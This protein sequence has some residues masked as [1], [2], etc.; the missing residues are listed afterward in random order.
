M[1]SLSKKKVFVLQDIS[2]TIS[3][4]ISKYV[5]ALLLLVIVGSAFAQAGR[6][7]RANHDYSHLSYKSAARKYER[8]IGRRSDGVPVQR[9]LANCYY[10]MSD[11][12]NAEKYF[13]MMI[14]SPEATPDD[15]FRY[16][17]ALK[18]NGKLDASDTYMNKLYKKSMA[19]TRAQELIRDANYM[20]KLENQQPSFELKTLSVNTE[21]S[22]F[23]GYPNPK[24]KEEVY[25]ISSRNNSLAVKN[26][27][28]WDGT[29]FLDV[30][31]G[32]VAADGAISNPKSVRGDVNTKYH[33]GPLTFTPNADYVYFTRNN[34]MGGKAKYDDNRIQN[35]HLYK[36][37]VDAKGN[38]DDEVLLPF[39]DRLYSVGH[40][41][42]SPD[43]SILYFASDMPGGFGGVDLYKVAINADGTYGKPENLGR[44]INSEGNEMFPWVSENGNFF[45]SSNGHLGYGGLDVFV[46]V[47]G[48]S[49]ADNGIMNLGK[50]INS[51]RDD[52]AF[53]LNPDCKTGYVSSNREGGL[54]DDDIYSVKMIKN[55]IHP[56]NVNGKITDSTSKNVLAFTT[57]Y[58]KDGNGAIIDST[59]TDENGNYT[60]SV[61]SESNFVISA[62][63]Q[64]YSCAERKITTEGLPQ[65]QKEVVANAALE[66]NFD[67]NLYCLV[68]NSKTSKPVHNA[69]ISVVD[70]VTGEVLM[71]G[72]TDLTGDLKTAVKNRMLGETL[73][74]IVEVEAD[75]FFPK[76]ENISVTIE[77]PGTINL[78][79]IMNFNMDQIEVGV[80]LAD[81]INLKPIYFDL[82]KWNIRRDAAK[83]LDKIVALMNKYPN[84]V[85]EL[86]SHTDCRSSMQFNQDLSDKRAKASAEY[87]KAKISDPDRIYGKGYGE[88]RL[89]VNCPCEGEVKSDC[90]ESEHAK[91]RR[92]EFVVIQL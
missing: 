32:S 14:E 7:K 35:L 74:M 68:T 56:V 3:M 12:V 34:I 59:K 37:K 21:F 88:T 80:D 60:F 39:N 42:I 26:E 17:Q 11:M 73:N 55:L 63:K 24:N 67:L 27:W 69:H 45:F 41:T 36:A 49:T 13:A 65:D 50:P 82:G 1:I 61:P 64:Y 71:S 81:A 18:Q 70:G 91:N 19:D 78:H 52:F 29:R 53:S 30:F 31:K 10:N 43:G 6:L 40:P 46:V 28:S 79:E 20:T 15:L 23:G 8:I 51:V 86:G 90:T 48:P 92:T 76:E 25:F 66:R 54:G 62:C 85:V 72:I 4:K 5:I 84:M 57:V 9:N 89:K 75:G 22:D 87:I 47:P 83:E 77:K 16:A 58:L 33:E 38:W 44:P 2:K